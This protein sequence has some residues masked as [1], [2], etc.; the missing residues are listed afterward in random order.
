M[1]SNLHWIPAAAVAVMGTSVHAVTY[2]T[3]EQ[4]SQ[5]IF[6][7]ERLVAAAFSLTPDQRKAVEKVSGVKVRTT[8]I[9]AWKSP[10]GGW[11]LVDDVIGKHEFITYALG[12]R[13]DGTILKIEVMDYRENY[14]DAV[15]KPE[16]RSQFVGKKHGQTLKLGEDIRNVS[17]ATLSCQHITQGVRRL[18]A[19]HALVLLSPPP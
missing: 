13:S 9:R 16:W 17:G 6:P 12:L 1:R 18:L 7:D 10:S 14:G 15:R 19:V 8:E 3:V 4:A 11:L 2:L 5:S